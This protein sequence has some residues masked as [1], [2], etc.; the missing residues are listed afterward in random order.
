M[1]L[2]IWAKVI[3]LILQLKVLSN[4]DIC[5]INI[6]FKP[7]KYKRV[8]SFWQINI[9]TWQ[10]WVQMHVL[11]KIC[12]FEW[13]STWAI[14]IYYTRTPLSFQCRCN[15]IVFVFVLIVL[16]GISKIKVKSSYTCDFIIK[17]PDFSSSNL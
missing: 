14:H 5:E 11:I 16:N 2:K 8:W 12:V 4:N 1:N 3:C 9:G 17:E 13:S 6:F 7:L 10:Y 15:R